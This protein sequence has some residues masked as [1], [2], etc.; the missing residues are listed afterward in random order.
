[1]QSWIYA[2]FHRFAPNMVEEYRDRRPYAL[3]WVPEA[4][5]GSKRNY[6]MELDRLSET[7]VKTCQ[8]LHLKYMVYY[9]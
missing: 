2:Y 6:R 5:K 7:D 4:N 3:Q 1:M 9:Y 8:Y